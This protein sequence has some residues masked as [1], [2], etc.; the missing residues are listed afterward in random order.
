MTDKTMEEQYP[1][2]KAV[3]EKEITSK[4]EEV[5]GPLPKEQTQQFVN[6]LEKVIIRT[7]WGGRNFAFVKDQS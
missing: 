1:E 6:W 3:F 7:Y 4:L 5:F 2:L